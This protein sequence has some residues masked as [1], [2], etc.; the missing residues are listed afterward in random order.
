MNK[1]HTGYVY[2]QTND[3]EV[4]EVVVYRHGRDGR[5]DRLGGYLTGGKGSGKPHLPSQASVV[6]GDGRLFVANAG[7]DEVTV[8]A[9]EGDVL[10]PIDRVPSGGS[11][12]TS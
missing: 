1:Q 6:L 8:F 12:P 7:S 4:N 11:T 3:A 5:L 9:V 10:V 2:V